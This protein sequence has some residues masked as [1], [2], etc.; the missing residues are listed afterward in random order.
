MT[1]GAAPRRADGRRRA[2]DAR[3]AVE[4]PQS[5][6]TP[7]PRLRPASGRQSSCGRPTCCARRARRSWTGWP[8]RPDAVA[9]SARSSSSSRCRCCARRPGAPYTRSGRSSRPTCPGRSRWRSAGRSGWSARSRRGTPHSCCP[10]ARSWHRWRSGTPSCSSRRRN[11]RG[12]A[13]VWAEIFAE[14]GL[15]AGV[16]NVVTHAPGE[17]GAIGAE[18]VAH[19][20]VRRIN[21]TGSTATGRRLAERPA[22]SQAG[23]PR[24]GGQ[25]P[26]IVLADA[27]LEYAVDASV[28]GAFLHQGQICMCARRISSNGPS[29]RI[30]RPVRGEGAA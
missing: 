8:P 5:A 22:A 1:R 25:N 23:R 19:P 27:D 10:G 3:L 14:A 13:A 26:L 18:L 21:F 9:T 7:G 2:G 6:F 4:L 29:P 30:P 24:L 16:L 28:Y 15:P 20:W 12:P 17:A 11:R